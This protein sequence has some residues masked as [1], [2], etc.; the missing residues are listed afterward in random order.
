MGSKR[1]LR[2]DV[3]TH[4]PELVKLRLAPNVFKHIPLSRPLAQSPAFFTGSDVRIRDPEL[5]KMHLAIAFKGVS[6]ADPDAIAL[7]VMQVSS[8]GAGRVV[9]TFFCAPSHWVPA[10]G[11]ICR[12]AAAALLAELAEYAGEPVL[13]CR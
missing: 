5:E 13:L 4:A 7:Q 1:G 11:S 9:L 8:S 6:W 12:Q 10:G 2:S 3:R